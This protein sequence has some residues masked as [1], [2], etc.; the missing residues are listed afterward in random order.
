MSWVNKTAIEQC[1]ALRTGEIT[2][3]ELLEIT[4]AHSESLIPHI[5]PFA[6]KLYDRARQT[7]NRLT[8]HY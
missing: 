8:Y 2:S 1:E 3:S 6:I 5:N 7:F 4:I